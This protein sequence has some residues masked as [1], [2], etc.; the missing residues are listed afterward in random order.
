ML[1]ATDI[2]T[3][4]GPSGQQTAG[5]GEQESPVRPGRVA[6]RLISLDR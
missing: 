6:Y 2:W 1:Y 5:W 3:T 4:D